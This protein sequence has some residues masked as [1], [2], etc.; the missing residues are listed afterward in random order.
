LYYPLGGTAGFNPAYTAQL[1]FTA[2]QPLLRGAGSEVN[3]APIRV[4]QLKRDQSALDVKSAMLAQ[5]R[6]IE[7]AYW[8]LQASCSNLQAVDFLL[9]L[10]KEAVRI[11]EVRLENNIV[12]EGEVARSRMLQNQFEQQRVQ[13]ATDVTN[14]QY[15]LANLMGLSRPDVIGFIPIDPPIRERRYVNPEESLELALKQRPDLIKQQIA[16]QIRDLNVLVADNLAKPQLDLQ[17]LWRTTGLA[18]NLDTALNQMADFKYNDWTLGAT[19][20]VP[21]GLRAARAAHRASEMDYAREMAILRQATVNVG[22]Q[23]AEITREMD[24]AWNEFSLATKRIDQTHEWLV[25]AAIR[26]ENPPPAQPGAQAA[27]A[28]QQSLLTVLLNDYQQAMRA[29]VDSVVNASQ[30][31]AR[32]NSQVARL[33]EAQ[34]T[35]L[36]KRNISVS[37]MSAPVVAASKKS[38]PAALPPQ[39]SPTLPGLNESPSTPLTPPSRFRSYR[40]FPTA[41]NPAQTDSR[42]Q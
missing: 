39:M 23:L 20:T 21:L 15:R 38:E 28:V 18:Q 11:E 10:L 3:L 2:Q 8:D 41:T 37:D 36:E 40:D 33:E 24:R 13:L 22:Y 34:G 42:S 32:Y 25:G 30:A 29:Y 1:I 27:G 12:T 6:S 4:A 17:A 16:V 9:P 35:L 19:C 5:V 7:E 14:K 26:F 31:L